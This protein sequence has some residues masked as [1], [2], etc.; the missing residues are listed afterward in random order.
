[1]NKE[2]GLPV[3]DCLD[4]IGPQVLYPNNTGGC[5]GSHGLSLKPPSP[6]WGS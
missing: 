6:R 5:F 3:L 1:M 2:A 4:H